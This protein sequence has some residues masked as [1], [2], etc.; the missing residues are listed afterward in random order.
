MPLA[1]VDQHGSQYCFEDTGPAQSS[2]YTTLVLVHGACFQ[3]VIFERLFVHAAAHNMRLVAV[4]MRD[5]RGSTPYSASELADLSSADVARQT[6]AIRA[7]GLELLTFI[8]W[9]IRTEGIPPLSPASSGNSKGGGG[10]AL[11]GWSWGNKITLSCVAQA[12]HLSPDDV[13]T[14]GRYMRTLI[15]FD[16]SPRAFGAPASSLE[17]SYNPLNDASLSPEAKQRVFPDWVSGYYS[18][19]LDGFPSLHRDELLAG[20]ARDPIAN[21]PPHQSATLHRMSSDEFAR[22][23]NADVV[24]RSHLFYELVDGKVYA[25]NTRVAL[26]STSIWPNVRV[27]LVWCDMSV[28]ETVLPAWGLLRQVQEDWPTNGRAIHSVRLKGANH[29][30]HWERPKRTMQL[31]DDLIRSQRIPEDVEMQG[32]EPVYSKL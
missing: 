22:I 12:S 6:A 18:H 4:N 5:Y 8:L 17:E 26:R 28:S 11:L 21:P 2:D 14:L 16:P 7:R 23:I 25:D 19:S 3:A 9:L 30:P 27:V 1:S 29:F 10:I 15:L 24:A 20:F 13:E 32:T 31:F